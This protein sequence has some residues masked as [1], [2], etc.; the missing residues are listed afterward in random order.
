M[1]ARERSLVVSAAFSQPLDKRWY[2][3]DSPEAKYTKEYFDGVGRD[4][5]IS[6]SGV[7]I[8]CH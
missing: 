5:V 2:S 3:S 4:I 6:C 8:F 1:G 7:F